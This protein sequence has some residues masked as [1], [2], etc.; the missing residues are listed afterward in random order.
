LQSAIDEVQGDS[1]SV[2]GLLEGSD[3]DEDCLVRETALQSLSDILLSVGKSPVKLK[4][5]GRQV[6]DS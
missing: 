2:K 3:D 5:L 1:L 4:R 6:P